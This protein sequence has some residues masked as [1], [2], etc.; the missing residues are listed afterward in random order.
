MIT[1]TLVDINTLTP[2]AKNP[3]IVKKEDFEKLKQSIKDNP[4]LFFDR[5]IIA[6]NRTG[7][8]IILCGNTRYRAAKELGMKEV[9]ASIRKL[10]KK[11]EDEWMI[12]DNVSNGL[13]DW[14]ILANEH[15]EEKLNEWGLEVWK[16]EEDAD[17]SI[18]DGEDLDDEM[19]GMRSGVKKALQIPFDIEHYDEAFELVK[20]WREQGAYVGKMLIDKLKDEK[21][22]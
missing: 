16:P 21:N 15:D 8:N 11:K 1:T 4:E 7:E 17:Y 6:S 2:N 5:P 14:E 19:N 13:W 12:R 22:K 20:Y 10:T 9:P 18:L 3:R